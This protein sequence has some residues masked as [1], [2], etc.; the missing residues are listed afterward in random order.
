M[1]Q[2]ILLSALKQS[3][4]KTGEVIPQESNVCESSR[5]AFF[6]T[7]ACKLHHIPESRNTLD[8]KSYSLHV[9]AYPQVWFALTKSSC[10]MCQLLLNLFMNSNYT[11][12]SCF[13]RVRMVLKVTRQIRTAG[14]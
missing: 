12:H 11:I 13:N 2:K 1:R 7:V 10:Y 8:G 9:N 3:R 6:I 4:T 5:V 14:R